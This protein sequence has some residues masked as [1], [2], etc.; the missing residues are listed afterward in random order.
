MAKTEPKTNPNSIN[1][2]AA[3]T[4]FKGELKTSSDIKI[5]GRFEGNITTQNKIVLGENGFIKGEIKCKN[6]IISGK[7]EGKIEVEELIRLESSAHI[8]GELITSKLAIEPGAILNG[9]CTMSKSAN[10]AS[11]K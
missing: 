2:I 11:E 10:V 3:S 4:D 6:A 9:T 8:D 7:I 5:D 1:F